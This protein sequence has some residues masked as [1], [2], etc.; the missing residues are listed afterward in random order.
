LPRPS[1]IA[2]AE[3][4]KAKAKANRG[5]KAPRK[6]RRPRGARRAAAKQKSQT[7]KRRNPENLTGFRGF[8]LFREREGDSRLAE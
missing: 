2:G 6:K 7:E 1:K 5:R 3:R 4:R 8:L